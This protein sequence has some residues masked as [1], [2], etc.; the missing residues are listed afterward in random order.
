MAQRNDFPERKYIKKA[1]E[2]YQYLEDET[3]DIMSA[4][5]LGKVME[6]QIRKKEDYVLN[7]GKSTPVIAGNHSPK[8]L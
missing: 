2:L 4:V 1:E 3:V 6:V 7:N 8:K 5:E